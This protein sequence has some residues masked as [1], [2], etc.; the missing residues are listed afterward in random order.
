MNINLNNQ[1]NKFIYLKGISGFG[2]R[3]RS[4]LEAVFYCHIT[5]RQL[6]VDWTDGVY[7]PKGV[8]AFDCFFAGPLVSPTHQ[9]WL[10]VTD[11]M[12]LCPA[13]W[14]GGLSGHWRERID[15]VQWRTD[16]LKRDNPYSYFNFEPDRFDYTEDV[17]V[18]I[19]W[20]FRWGLF[21]NHRQIFPDEFK[22]LSRDAIKKKLLLDHAHL[23]QHI[24]KKIDDF[25]SDHFR[26]PMIGVHVRYT[27]N[28]L[29]KF[30]AKR[31]VIIDDYFPVIDKLLKEQPNSK[32]FLCTDNY[33]VLEFF[34]ENYSD[35]VST[36]KFYP[37][38]N[39]AIHSS[40]L[41][42]DKVQMGEE[43]LI[44]M[45][46]LSRCGH[47][48]HTGT[49]SFTEIPL[50][51]LGPEKCFSVKTLSQQP[52][53]SFSPVDAGFLPRSFNVMAT[54]TKNSLINVALNKPASQSSTSRWSQPGEAQAAVNGIKSG[55]HSFHTDL[56]PHPWWQ[57]DLG[58]IYPVTTITVYNR[59]KKGTPMADRAK[60]LIVLVST[61]AA[62][63]VSV[64]AGGESFG[65]ATDNLP[66]TVTCQGKKARYV[67][68]ELQ[69]A[70]YLHLDEVEVMSDLSKKT[71]KVTSK[72][73]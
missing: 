18:W 51:L 39:G 53:N 9:P 65:G 28:L 43:A 49:S 45:Y 3:I 30:I 24:S 64:Y 31:N 50:L 6:I 12:T 1:S 22:I 36:N 68:L 60:S 44:D 48:V 11:E 61:D 59:G 40:K 38:D 37:E 23:N 55:E 27:D 5:G 34:K 25:A 21:Q 46:L 2:N 58:K 29:Q 4:Y 19:S 15:F 67:K 41:C 73:G 10:A 42:Q 52:F 17:L 72:R 32:I 56:E 63:W 20:T 47:V 35:I 13:S 16:D 26:Q 8:N 70:N 57:V 71:A 7:A 33:A 14:K 69:E 54:S 62:S 66:L